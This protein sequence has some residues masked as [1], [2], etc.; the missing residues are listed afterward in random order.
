MQSP[1]CGGTG[2]GAG[3]PK[4][5][6]RDTLTAAFAADIA[7]EVDALAGTGAADGI[8]FEALETAV[9][10]SAWRPGSWSGG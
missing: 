1:A 9:R 2:R 4:R 8:D 3:R 10:R 6:L 5:G 7:A